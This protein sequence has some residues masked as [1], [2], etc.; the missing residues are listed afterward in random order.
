MCLWRASAEG[1]EAEHGPESRS[2]LQVQSLA[3]VVSGELVVS[4][5]EARRDSGFESV[6]DDSVLSR[7]V[8]AVE[9]FE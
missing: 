7:G 5:V 4:W 9:S 1:K 6:S 8:E 2:H 3:S